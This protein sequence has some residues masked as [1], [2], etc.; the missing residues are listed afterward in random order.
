LKL[1]SIIVTAYPNMSLTTE[2]SKLWQ[3]MLQAVSFDAAQVNLKQHILSNRFPPTI[4]DI[5]RHDPEVFTD[6]KKMYLDTETY[7]LQLEERQ[8]L[9]IDCPPQYSRKHLKSGGKQDV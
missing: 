5:T 7:L 9:A 4:A 3:E 6:Y 2:V 8:R 1:L